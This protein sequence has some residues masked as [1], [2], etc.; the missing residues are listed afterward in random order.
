MYIHCMHNVTRLR[1]NVELCYNKQVTTTVV[2]KFYG[3]EFKLDVGLYRLYQQ[4]AC[5][6][7]RQTL[8]DAKTSVRDSVASLLNR[9]G[10][11]LATA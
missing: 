3:A 11:S 5:Q 4:V 8:L 9:S 1:K 10:F 7:Y 6:R 2:A